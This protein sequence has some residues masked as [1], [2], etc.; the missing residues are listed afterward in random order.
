MD[1][2]TSKKRKLSLGQTDVKK[3][4]ATEGSYGIFSEMPGDS[5]ENIDKDEEHGDLPE[6]RDKDE[7]SFGGFNGS[8]GHYDGDGDDEIDDDDETD[9]DDEMDEDDEDD[10]E[11]K[12]LKSINIRIKAN[13]AADSPEVGFCKARLINRDWIRANFHRD[14]E[15]ASDH[16]STVGFGLFNRW[17]C[18]KSEYMTHPV[19]KGTGVWGPELN[20]GRFALIE[21]FEV[22]EEYQRKGY[23]KELFERAWTEAQNLA[24][25]AFCDCNFAIIFASVLNSQDLGYQAMRLPFTEQEH[26]YQKAYQEKQDAL[27]GF[28]R[29]M[30]FRRIGSSEFFCFA[31]NPDHPSRSLLPQDDYMYPWRLRISSRA[32]SQDFPLVD[33]LPSPNDWEHKTY[34]DSQTKELLEARLQSHPV[35][36]PTWTSTDAHENNILHVLARS[37]KLESLTWALRMPF[38]GILRSARNLEGETPLEALESRLESARTCKSMQGIMLV[39]S[40]QFSGFTPKQVECLKLLSCMKDPN[41]SELSQ[42][43]FGCTCGQCLAG[44]L[45]PRVAF[46]LVC[47]AEIHH[48]M[49]NDDVGNGI[50][51]CE[52]WDH[53]FK[54][55]PSN[56]KSNLQTN[57]SMRQGFVN[58]F[59][60]IARIL[61]ARKL[62]TTDNVLFIS[63]NENEWPP[64]TRTSLQRG[65]TVNAALQACFDAA[66]DQDF[67]SGNGEHREMFEEEINA[68]PTCR[69]DGEFVFVRRMC[70]QLEGLPDEENA[71]VGTGGSW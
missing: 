37:A 8:R 40:D 68:L 54:H 28:W 47:Q 51:W 64:H 5:G 17:G 55:L 10:E 30:G 3:R 25:K 63:S 31:K 69:N 2:I 22:K 48:D 12:W 38:A 60:Y 14:M 62:P 50:R 49:Q 16:T 35:T 65:G 41:S 9:H 24:K 57:K 70:G 58:V 59:G 21:Y 27:E 46:A 19:K 45:S 32:D 61:Q 15:E 7:D 33:L 11:F 34:N 18:L 1:P 42:L 4:L 13:E 56:V 39:M 52:S 6:E 26:F 71:R 44:F 29:A 36:D 43:T 66:M 67:D 23:G 53:T 20:K